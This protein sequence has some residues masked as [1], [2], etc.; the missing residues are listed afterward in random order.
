MSKRLSGKQKLLLKSLEKNYYVVTK[1]CEDVGV[2][3]ITYYW[4][5]DHNDLFAEKAKEVEKD[6]LIT[7]EDRLK[8]SALK[9]QPWAVRFFL[10]RKHP[11]YKVKIHA[12][13]E[14]KFE[15]LFKNEEGKEK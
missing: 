14:T 7:I 10:G 12:E 11:D 1:A 9:D 13:E 4:W 2:P 8:L 15:F 5:M 3:R 6:L